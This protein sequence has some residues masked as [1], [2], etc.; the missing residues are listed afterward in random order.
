MREW[1]VAVAIECTDGD[2]CADARA[3]DGGTKR[4]GVEAL[5]VGVDTGLAMAFQ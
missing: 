4:S 1:L 2:V 5:A 3:L